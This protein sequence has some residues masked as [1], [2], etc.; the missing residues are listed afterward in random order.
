MVEPAKESPL[1]LFR[2]GEMSRGV[3]GGCGFTRGMAR[4]IEGFRRGGG[5]RIGATPGLGENLTMNGWDGSKMDGCGLIRD[6]GSNG[7][8][9]KRSDDSYL[10]VN[11]TKSNGPYS[12]TTAPAYRAST[13]PQNAMSSI[14]NTR[15]NSKIKGKIVNIVDVLIILLIYAGNYMESQVIRRKKKLLLTRFRHKGLMGQIK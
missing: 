2:S 14:K 1:L 3:H 8:Y 13:G 5:G 9:Q 7:P 12:T 4:G 15:Q 6:S 10:L 11:P